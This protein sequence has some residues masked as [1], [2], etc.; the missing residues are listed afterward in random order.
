VIQIYKKE[1]IQEYEIIDDKDL[2]YNFKL[3][4][5]TIHLSGDDEK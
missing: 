5:D 3:F 4:N 1:N 2:V